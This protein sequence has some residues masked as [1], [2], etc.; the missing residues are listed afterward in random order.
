MTE[1]ARGEKPHPLLSLRRPRPLL[2]APD[3]GTILF[4]LAAFQRWQV[5]A[6]PEHHTVERCLSGREVTGQEGSTCVFL[7]AVS[8]G[9]A[10]GTPGDREGGVG[11]QPLSLIRGVLALL[12]QT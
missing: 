10:L 8:P 12:E 6:R 11:G 3:T 9:S 1:G 4:F 7:A 2:H 5:G